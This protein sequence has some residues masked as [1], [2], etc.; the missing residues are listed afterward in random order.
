M[1]ENN[2][3]TVNC[4]QIVSPNNDTPCKLFFSNLH[5]HIQP[6]VTRCQPLRGILARKN[7]RIGFGTD[8]DK[9]ASAFG[10]N[11]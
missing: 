8:Y 6:F 7:G 1:C 9:M 4:C 5:R 11:F 10:L 3:R 2:S